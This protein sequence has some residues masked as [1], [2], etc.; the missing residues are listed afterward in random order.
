MNVIASNDMPGRPFLNALIKKKGVGG[1]ARAY[2]VYNSGQRYS[3]NVCV[4]V[5]HWQH[6]NHSLSKK[7]LTY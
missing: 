6:M 7:K 2:I 4:F 5:R 1:C 3:T